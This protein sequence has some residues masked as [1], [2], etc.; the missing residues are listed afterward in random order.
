MRNALRLVA[1]ALLSS[2]A[3]ACA[4]HQSAIPGTSSTASTG[5]SAAT[6]SRQTESIADQNGWTPFYTTIPAS[7]VNIKAVR[8]QAS[9]ALTVPFFTGSI[10]SPL[11][12]N[13]Y[14]FDIVGKNPQTSTTTTLV[15]F[16]PIVMRMHFNDGTILDPTAP[17][18]NDTAS[19]SNRFFFGPNFL[20]TNLTSNGISV[21]VTQINDAFQRAEFWSFVSGT[22]YHTMLEAA[23]PIRVV[24]VQAPPGSKT[25][26]GVC[27]GTSH[28][29]GEIPIGRFDEIIRGLALSFATPTQVPI[30][31]SY[32]VFQ[33]SNGHCCIIGYHSAF[34]RLPGTQVYAVSAYNDAG[35]FSVP[36]EDIHAWTHEIGELFNDPFVNNATPPWGH[37]GQVSGCQGNL[38]VGDPLTGVPFEVTL[39]GF[40]YHPQELAFFSWFFRTPSTGTAGLFS[41][42]GTFKTAQG[43]CV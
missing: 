26:K 13:T 23:A 2:L 30:V 29:I 8:A 22:G 32:N 28:R 34:S 3:A 19:V 15:K 43:V 6:S 40:T 33:T 17:G 39:N 1:V 38:E 41:F 16:V 37:V 14:T 35:I 12:G 7:D 9:P 42:E 31:L 20:S 4:G 5:Q 27:A 11:D 10:K 18:C 24:D 36:I 25:H 21:G